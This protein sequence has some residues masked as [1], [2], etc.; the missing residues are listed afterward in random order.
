M[1]VKNRFL[2]IYCKSN[3]FDRLWCIQPKSGFGTHPHRDMEIFTYV[4]EGK[5]THKDR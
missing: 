1:I 3:Y 2:N 4:V 5:L